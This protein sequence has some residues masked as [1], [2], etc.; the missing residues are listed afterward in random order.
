MP[1][2]SVF[3]FVVSTKILSSTSVFNNIMVTLYFKV[4]FSL[5]TNHLLQ[6]IISCLLILSKVVIKFRI[7]DVEYGHAEYVVYKYKRLPY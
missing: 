6:L 7:R 1:K 5:L 2:N 4:Q 3:F